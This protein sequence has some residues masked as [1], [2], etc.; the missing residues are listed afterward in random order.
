MIIIA[1]K[2]RS[3]AMAERPRKALF[4]I[5]VRCYSQ[6]HAQNWIFGPPYGDIRSN[7]CALSEIFNKKNLVAEFH[8]E[9]V[10]FSRKTTN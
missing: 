5:N 7:I 6:N 2:T 9:N 3:S 4:S 8:R 1:V 10:S